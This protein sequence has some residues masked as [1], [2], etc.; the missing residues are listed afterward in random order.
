M[1]ALAA[2]AKQ[3]TAVDVSEP[4]ISLALRNAELNSFSERFSTVKSDVFDFLKKTFSEN[5]R[6]EAIILDPPAFCKSK[7]TKKDSNSQT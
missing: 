1:H 3:V 4:A 6:Y 5:R 2:G 7:K